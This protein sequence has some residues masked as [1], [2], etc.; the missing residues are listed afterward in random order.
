M[1]VSSLSCLPNF[2]SIARILSVPFAV[3]FIIESQWRA[4][5]FLFVIAAVS[6]GLDGFL[7]RFFSFQSRVGAVLDALADKLLIV[8]V[9]GTL[10]V[11]TQFPLL[12]AML[13][14]SRDVLIIGGVVAGSMF[15]R[16]VVIRPL[17][18]SKAT[19]LAQCVLLSSILATHAFY[20]EAEVL[21]VSIEMIT[22][23]LTMISGG[24]YFSGWVA[25][26]RVTRTIPS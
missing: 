18:V 17:Y 15:A 5:F 21:I 6:D 3:K 7:A 11:S 22:A 16:P 10:V 8:S 9:V 13:I 1:T 26:M 25:H 24:F 14:I 4:A 20:L 12:L 23:A 2:I 19:T